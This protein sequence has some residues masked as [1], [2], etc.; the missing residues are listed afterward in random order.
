MPPPQL[1]QYKSAHTLRQRRFSEVLGRRGCATA[2]VCPRPPAGSLSA[3]CASTATRR[4]SRR[5]QPSRARAG[6]GTVGR[7]G[8]LTARW[9]NEARRAGPPGACDRRGGRQWACVD[10]IRAAR[11][12]VGHEAAGGVRRSRLSPAGDV[13]RQRG[14]RWLSK[15]ASRT[16]GELPTA[17]HHL[18]RGARR[19]TATAAAPPMH[20]RR[21]RVVDDD[22]P[23]GAQVSPTGWGASVRAPDPAGGPSC[24]LARCRL[25]RVAGRA[26]GP[27]SGPSAGSGA[28]RRRR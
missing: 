8:S 5:R 1:P 12:G 27:P 23:E 2:H 3:S 10:A 4:T 28:A 15:T 9:S 19:A 7:L 20:A 25:G 24:G 11:C 21:G 13:I 17:L 26:P 14:P 6:R 22:D 16:G 18:Q